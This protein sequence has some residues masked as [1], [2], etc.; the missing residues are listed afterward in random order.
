MTITRPIDELPRAQAP[1]PPWCGMP[2]GHPYESGGDGWPEQRPH[3]LTLFQSRTVQAVIEAWGSAQA[4][5]AAESL[6][7]PLASCRIE[8]K[9]GADGEVF[10]DDLTAA[11]CRELAERIPQALLVAAEWLEAQA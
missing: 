6:A 11:Q 4:N 5:G 7:T 3:V 9:E 10:L 2:S 8:F 1:C